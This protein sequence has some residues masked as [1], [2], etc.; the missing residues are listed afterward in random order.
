MWKEATWNMLRNDNISKHL[1]SLPHPKI[2]NSKL[3]AAD[4]VYWLMDN[5][6]TVKAY[7][8]VNTIMEELNETVNEPGQQRYLLGE[9]E[10]V[11]VPR[12]Y[13]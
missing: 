13:R 12:T 11:G 10:N 2:P 5:E 3:N 7:H 6:H 9:I 8:F 4:Y 1:W